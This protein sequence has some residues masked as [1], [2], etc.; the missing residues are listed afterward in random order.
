VN[1]EPRFLEEIVGMRA[2][3][4]LRS[5]EAEQL[6]AGPLDE[7]GSR[8]EIAVLIA[9]HQQVQ[10]V[11]RAHSVG[12]RSFRLPHHTPAPT[13]RGIRAPTHAGLF[14]CQELIRSMAEKSYA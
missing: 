13:G 12:S 9:G 11:L 2:A 14:S 6:G 10:V 3:G 4:L 1:P 7:R 8:C 5:E